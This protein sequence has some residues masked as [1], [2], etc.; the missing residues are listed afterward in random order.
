M[1]AFRG[2]RSNIEHGGAICMSAA[3]ASG[4]MDGWMDRVGGE[5]VGLNYSWMVYRMGEL[6]KEEEKQM[7]PVLC[8]LSTICYF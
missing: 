3:V 6:R 5:S 2:N 8:Y 4:E 1:K 7:C